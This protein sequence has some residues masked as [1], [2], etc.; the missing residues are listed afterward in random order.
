MACVVCVVLVFDWR[1]RNVRRNPVEYPRN[2]LFTAGRRG[3][4][5]RSDTIGVGATVESRPRRGLISWV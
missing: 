1:I 5:S 2:V 3:F 4:W